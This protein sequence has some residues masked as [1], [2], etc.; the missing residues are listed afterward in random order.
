MFVA[1]AV[2]NGGQR[3]DGQVDGEKSEGSAEDN[4]V[5]ER[6]R[7]EWQMVTVLLDGRCWKD[8]ERLVP[9][10]GVNL[11]PVEIGKVSIIGNPC[12]HFV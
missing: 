12:L 8:E 5:D 2:A 3:I 6:V 11:L 7:C 10:E 1:L 4:V 9:G